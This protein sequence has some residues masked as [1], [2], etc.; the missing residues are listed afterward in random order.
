MNQS[1][2]YE[3]GLKLAAEQHKRTKN[4]TGK[5][6]R[7]HRTRLKKIIDRLQC[8]TALDYGCG[9]G[10]QYTWRMADGRSLEEFWNVAVTKYDPAYPPFA[11]EP[12]GKFDLVICTHVLGLIPIVDLQSWVIDRVFGFASK[13]VYVG[14]GTPGATRKRSKSRWRTDTIP[15]DWQAQD[16]LDLFTKRRPRGIEV[17]YTAKS[18]GYFLITDAGTESL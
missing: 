8:R 4:Y 18:V 16:W 3:A 7:P 12:T 17:H 15:V 1:A 9:R 5:F 11:A 14:H 6:L 13:A 10:D 2:E